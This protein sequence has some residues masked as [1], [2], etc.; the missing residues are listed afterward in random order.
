V[1][2]AINIQR[3]LDLISAFLPSQHYISQTSVHFR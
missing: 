3:M 2:S 1:E